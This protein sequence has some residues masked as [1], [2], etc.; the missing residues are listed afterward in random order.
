MWDHQTLEEVP[1]MLSIVQRQK[2][3]WQSSLPWKKKKKKKKK[4]PEEEAN[5]AV[6]S[7]ATVLQQSDGLAKRFI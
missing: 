6:F 7:S 4:T 3:N 1:E 5:P 2:S